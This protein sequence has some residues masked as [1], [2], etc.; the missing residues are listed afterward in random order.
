MLWKKTVLRHSAASLPALPP[1]YKPG[2]VLY[3]ARRGTRSVTNDLEL[4]E[5]LRANLPVPVRRVH[6]EHLKLAEQLHLVAS[7]SIIVAV[8][9]MAL[10]WAVF[11]DTSVRAAVVEIQPPSH[12]AEWRFMYARLSTSRGVRVAQHTG[13]LA[14]NVQKAKTCGSLSVAKTVGCCS[15]QVTLMCNVSVVPARVVSCVRDALAWTRNSSGA[16]AGQGTSPAEVVRC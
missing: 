14:G 15:S 9:G 2:S 12:G 6:M 7:S 1:P 11:L 8:H 16:A 13:K 3:I 10:T 4:T 5:A